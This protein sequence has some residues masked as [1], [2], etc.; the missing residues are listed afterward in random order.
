MD[1]A[2]LTVLLKV[3]SSLDVKAESDLDKYKGKIAGKIILMHHNYF[4]A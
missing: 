1:T 3:S 4:C 2:A